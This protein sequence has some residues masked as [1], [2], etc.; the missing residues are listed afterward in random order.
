MIHLEVEHRADQALHRYRRS[1]VPQ[2]FLADH[3]GKRSTGGIATDH[4]TPRIDA[5]RDGL[6][7][8]PSNSRH[9]ILDR[10]RE[11]VLGGEAVVYG[12]EPAARRLSQRRRNEIVSLD[13]AGNHAAAMK[14]DEAWQCFAGGIGGRIK[15]VGNRACRSRQHAI[16]SAYGRYIGASE[17]HQ[18][19]ERLAAG[20]SARP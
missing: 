18:F 9:C 19:G 5:Q 15:T 11:L 20:F 1:G 4:Q 12:D 14:E 2:T 3:G 16:N 13:T 8:N 17:L 6:V 10:G 7:R